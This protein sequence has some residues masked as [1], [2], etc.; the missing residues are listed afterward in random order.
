MRESGSQRQGSP[1]PEGRRLGHLPGSWQMPGPPGLLWPL[2]GPPPCTVQP[3]ARPPPWSLLTPG[4]A[5]PATVAVGG[6]RS[7]PQSRCTVAPGAMWPCAR[8]ALKK[9]RLH[10]PPYSV[11]RATHCKPPPRTAPSPVGLAAA[12]LRSLPRRWCSG[13]RPAPTWCAGRAT[14]GCWCWLASATAFPPGWP[15]SRRGSAAVC[16]VWKWWPC[17]CRVMWSAWPR[18]WRR[19]PLPGEDPAGA[20]WARRGAVPARAPEAEG[21][22]QAA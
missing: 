9:L 13:A 1:L 18:L 12:G 14:G 20:W 7:A 17:I 10:G 4:R 2:P 3:V 8:R 16:P 19:G 21:P 11:L 5:E 22:P 15:R 6:R